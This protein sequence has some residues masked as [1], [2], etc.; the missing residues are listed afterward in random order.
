M[1]NN[2]LANLREKIE[3]KKKELAELKVPK[4]TRMML[5]GG[6]QTRP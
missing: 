1:V 5:H 3:A 2:N 4:I 6:L